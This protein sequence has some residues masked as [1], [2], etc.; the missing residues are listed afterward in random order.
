MMIRKN[1]KRP[2]GPVRCFAALLCALLAA[3]ALSVTGSAA[4][5]SNCTIKVADV[6]HVIVEVTGLKLTYRPAET[7]T[8]SVT[9]E[10]GWQ[11]KSLWV[12]DGTDTDENSTD[13][14]FPE[15]TAPGSGQYNF[16]IPA[17]VKGPGTNSLAV[18]AEFVE[19]PLL[20]ST[21]ADPL[22]G[23]TVQVSLDD[24]TWTG[25]VSAW[26]GQTVYLSA[27]P[28]DGYV[29]QTIEI[30]GDTFREINHY[31]KASV[32]MNRFF[33][34]PA[35]AVTVT[36]TFILG[37]EAEP[38]KPVKPEEPVEPV[39][40][41]VSTDPPASG[42]SS[43]D[44]DRSGRSGSAAAADPEPAV[45]EPA[46]T[47]AVTESA[48]C[49][50]DASCPLSRFRDASPD[51]WYHDG[52]HRALEKGL[53]KGVS[54]TA[55][56]P[57]APATRAMAVTMLWRLEGQPEG[58]AASFSDVKPG[59]WY[60]AAVNWAAETGLVKGVSE[61]AFAPDAPVTREQLAAILY[62]YVQARGGGF[63]GAWAFPLEFPDAA[64]V[65]QWADEAMHWMTMNGILTGRDDGALAPGDTASRAQLAE[66][67]LRAWGEPE[68]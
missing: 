26:R 48:P 29:L 9:P 20:V 28:A 41:A 2:G 14:I 22:I 65:S 13:R 53:M 35:E 38:V 24:K 67:F 7:V 15:E 19:I 44:R 59:S 45:T 27:T 56:A 43:R 1:T 39:T 54:E 12:V 64:D 50:K 30:R 31:N 62:R 68:A 66:L 18:H 51:A 23:G 63:T 60:E 33:D 6:N 40:P 52:V 61:T 55:F 17:W 32:A 11:L 16:I 21:A 36:A 25:S 37:Q 47:Q 58:K 5:D 42:S 10:E 8:L 3:G 34:M 49:L 57:D 4:D 46:V